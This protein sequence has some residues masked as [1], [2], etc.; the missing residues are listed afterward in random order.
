MKNIKSEKAMLRG[1]GHDDRIVL[2]E[3]KEDEI[4]RDM[5]GD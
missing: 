1:S 3:T 2:S 5:Q 4:V